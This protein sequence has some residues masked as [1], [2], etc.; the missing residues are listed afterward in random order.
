MRAA[1]IWKRFLHEFWFWSYIVLWYAYPPAHRQNSPSLR[2][3][4]V[5]A[6]RYI[7]VP[8]SKPNV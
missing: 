2:W 3:V 5:Q 1:R 8:V 6:M 7:E 4:F